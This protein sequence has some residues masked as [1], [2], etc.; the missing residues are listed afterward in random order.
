MDKVQDLL[1]DSKI[2][3]YEKSFRD[4]GCTNLDQIVSMTHEVLQQLLEHVQ[5]IDKP[6]DKKDSSQPLMYIKVK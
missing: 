1:K 2:S 5:L 6:G 4:N 3:D